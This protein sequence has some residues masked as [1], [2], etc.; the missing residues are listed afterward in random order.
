M[1]DVTSFSLVD[2]ADEQFWFQSPLPIWLIGQTEYL[3][4]IIYL[5][6]NEI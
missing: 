4:K 5:S 2:F 1:W 3:N 6:E